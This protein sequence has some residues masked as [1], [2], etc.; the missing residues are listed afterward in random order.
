MTKLHTN[1]ERTTALG[2]A[3][4]GY[5]FL[6]AAFAVDKAVG[7][8][9]GYEVVA[10]I[11]VL[12]LVGHGIELSLK[13]YLLQ[14]GFTLAELKTLGHNLSACFDRAEQYGLAKSVSFDEHE[15]GAFRVLDDLYSTKQ[16]EY[17]VTGAKQFPMFGPLQLFAVK[18]FNVVADMV[19][20]RK[21]F[22][23]LVKA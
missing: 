9:E 14:H 21:H 7:R 16:L 23:G 13:S 6:E 18:L 10:P 17:I 4:Y 22:E 1:P 12:Y 8:N 20:F 5:D 15:M 19:G 11:P 3:R 2:M